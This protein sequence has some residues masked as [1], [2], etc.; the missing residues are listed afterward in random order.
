MLKRM[1]LGN[2]TELFEYIVKGFRESVSQHKLS[3]FNAHQ[4]RET[5]NGE[6]FINVENWKYNT[7][8]D[9]DDENEVNMFFDIISN[10]P[11]DDLR[12]LL[13]FVTGSSLVPE[14]VKSV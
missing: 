11:Q 13:K 8:Y 9:S 12:K 6:R 14:Y 3:L 1:F 5:I 7:V 2:N 4:L 10:W